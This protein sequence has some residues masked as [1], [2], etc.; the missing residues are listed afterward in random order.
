MPYTQKV[1]YPDQWKDFSTLVISRESY[2]GNVMSARHW[3][4]MVNV[5]KL[6]KPVN[7]KEWN[8]S[9][10]TYNA[11]YSPS[12]NSRNHAACRAVFDIQV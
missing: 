11:N 5:N 6:G 8:M 2:A 7:H 4:Y 1:G 9:P 12:N 10:Q 3:A